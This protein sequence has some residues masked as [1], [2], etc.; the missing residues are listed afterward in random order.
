MEELTRDLLVL[1]VGEVVVSFPEDQILITG[2]V[3]LAPCSAG[4][5][6]EEEVGGA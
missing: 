6:E 4:G 5:E 3:A 1:E 2:T